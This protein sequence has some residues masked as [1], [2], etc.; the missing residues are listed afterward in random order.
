MK[1][2]LLILALFGIC[3]VLTSGPAFAQLSNSYQKGMEYGTYY[4]LGTSL[5]DHAYHCAKYPTTGVTYCWAYWGGESNGVY[6]PYSGGYGD[7]TDSKCTSTR[8]G[9]IL[10]Y[11]VTGVCHQEAN[12]GL[13]TA[14]RTIGGGSVRGYT[15]S[16]S[17][18]GTLGKDWTVCKT[19]CALWW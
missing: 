3:F 14:G 18:F 10:A 8:V 5:A 6:I 13:Y 12:R 2:A 17:L 7:Y 15:L 1:K 9:C 16:C 19:A 4:I 11:A